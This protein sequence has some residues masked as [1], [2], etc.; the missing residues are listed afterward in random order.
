MVIKICKIC[1]KEFDSRGAAKC[2]SPECTS[3]IHD[4]FHSI[5]GHGDNTPE[6]WYE[7]LQKRG[8]L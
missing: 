4:E 6:Q 1:G 8:D 3:A 7:F 2:C 5:Y